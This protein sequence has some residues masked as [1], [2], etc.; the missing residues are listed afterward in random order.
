[1]HEYFFKI[2]YEQV[3]IVSFINTEINI[4][5]TTMSQNNNETNQNNQNNNDNDCVIVNTDEN[6]TQNV[7]QEAEVVS[8]SE[9]SESSNNRSGSDIGD[10]DYKVV[11]LRYINEKIMTYSDNKRKCKVGDCKKVWNAGT[12]GYPVN[13]TRIRQHIWTHHKQHYIAWTSTNNQTLP[14]PKKQGRLDN[15]L[16]NRLFKKPEPKKKSERKP[17]TEELKEQLLMLTQV[18]IDRGLQYALEKFTLNWKYNLEQQQYDP[19]CKLIIKPQIP[20]QTTF[21]RIIRNLSEMIKKDLIKHHLKGCSVN[22]ITDAWQSGG[23][24]YL[25]IVL[26]FFIGDLL[27]ELDWGIKKLKGEV[28][29]VLVSKKL[30]PVIKEL[31]EW[32]SNINQVV[33]TSDCGGDIRNAAAAL[34][35]DF[36]FLDKDDE[37]HFLDETARMFGD[38]LDEARYLDN[39]MDDD[40]EDED[41]L[42]PRNY[43]MTE[44][45]ELDYYFDNYVEDINSSSEEDSEE[46]LTSINQTARPILN[47]ENRS[48]VNP[49]QLVQHLQRSNNDENIKIYWIKGGTFFGQFV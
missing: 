13:N 31:K 30:K 28:N 36:H 15:F 43:S 7:N 48:V 26:R 42:V 2:F 14:P 3:K 17:T 38:D 6:N 16:T 4:V 32:N 11:S 8:D 25:L 22:I 5:K 47:N 39:S 45:E 49:R 12:S 9:E 40:S 29:A 41:F 23:K 21:K 44:E 33:I 10:K 1:M 34:D 35:K 27:V 24:K 18:G 20:H 19:K 46:D 37:A